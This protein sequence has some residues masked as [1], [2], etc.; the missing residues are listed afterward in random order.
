M[1]KVN[2]LFFLFLIA[3]GIFVITMASI[4][5]T[6]KT[7]NVFYSFLEYGI[8]IAILIFSIYLIYSY[9]KRYSKKNNLK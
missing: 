7:P 4:V 3:F 6:T 1:N 5:F 8:Y 9:I 2:K